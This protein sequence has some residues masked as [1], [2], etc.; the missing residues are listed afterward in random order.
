MACRDESGRLFL[1][2]CRNMHMRSDVPQGVFYMLYEKCEKIFL[3][4]F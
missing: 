4:A 1:C 2:L 3:A